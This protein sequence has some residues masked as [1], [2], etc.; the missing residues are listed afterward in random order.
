[1]KF[2]CLKCDSFMNYE[3][4]EL[5]DT[6]R[7]GITFSCTSCGY[8]V[9]LV[10]NPGETQ[11]VSGLGVKIGGRTVPPSPMEFTR[12]ALKTEESP[13]ATA[14]DMSKCPFSAMVAGTMG[15]SSAT[16][17]TGSGPAWTPSAQ[18]RLEN[19]PSFVRLLAQTGIEQYAREKGYP[20]INDEV[21]QEYREK[22]GM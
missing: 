9:A 1:M 4:Q 15:Q 3:S 14:V 16:A 19:I 22:V 8:K 5:V 11:L 6:L 7:L 13:A 20:E 18:K 17:K 21:M 10:T 2:L 12:E